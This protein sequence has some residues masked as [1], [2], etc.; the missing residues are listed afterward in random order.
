MKNK[1]LD[2]KKLKNKLF[3]LWCKIIHSRGAC[4]LCGNSNG[5]LDAH[6][7]EGRTGSLLY[8]LDNGILLCFRCHRLGVH[9]EASSVQA[10]TRQRIIDQRGQEA[11]ENL[12]LQRHIPAKHSTDDLI[13]LLVKYTDAARMLG[14]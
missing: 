10:A 8:N 7:I 1:K 11:M 2:P 6:H 9:S 13:S 14:M 12:K 5:K 4:E 3:K